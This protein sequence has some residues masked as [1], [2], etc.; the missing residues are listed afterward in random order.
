L[1]QVEGF[2]PESLHGPSRVD[3]EGPSVDPNDEDLG[4]LGRR[5]VEN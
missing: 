3:P 2:E 5:S 1:Q 4:A